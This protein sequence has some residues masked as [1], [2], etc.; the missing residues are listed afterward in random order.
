MKVGAQDLALRSRHGP[1]GAARLRGRRAR[2][3]DAARRA[4]H[5]QGPGRRLAL[6]P[7][8]LPDDDLRL[9]RHAHGRRRRARVQDADVRD[10]RGRPHPGH[11]GHGQPPRRQGPRRRHG[12]VLGQDA[13]GPAVPPARLPGSRR[14]GVRRP[15]RAGG[16]D[17]QGD[18]LHQLRLLRLRVQLDGGRPRVPRPGRARQGDALRRRLARRAEDRAARVVLRGARHLGLHA[19]LL[20]PGALS[21]GRRPAG[22]DREARRGGDEGRHRPRHGREAREVVRDVCEDDRLAAR[23]GARAE[24]AGRRA[25]DQGDPVCDA[26]P[27]ARQGAAARAAARRE[28]RRPGAR[29]LRPREAAGPR[30]RRRH[31]PGREGARADR[32]HRGA[33]ATREGGHA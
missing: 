14:G 15:A 18:A 20:L 23:D 16:A 12:P 7:Q 2:L 9:V 6:V 1:E 8:E 24:D 25:L 21:Q 13:R 5:R 10:R 3:G 33:G 4:R 30:R 32:V 27:Q 19:L 17:P 11:L 22:R 31:R 29:A 28:G 26:A